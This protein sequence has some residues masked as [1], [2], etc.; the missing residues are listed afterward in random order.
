MDFIEQEVDLGGF[1]FGAGYGLHVVDDV[2]GHG[3]Y[4]VKALKIIGCEFASPLA[5][6]VEAILTGDFLGEVVWGFADVIAVGAGAVD[7]PVQARFAGLILE[8]G[9][10]EGAAADIA[11]ADHEYF[12]GGK[13]TGIAGY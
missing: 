13:G 4:L 2:A 3:I 11:K 5:A 6:D 10:G 9:F 7:L 8:Y 12:H 1:V